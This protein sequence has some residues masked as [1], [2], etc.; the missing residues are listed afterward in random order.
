MS[1]TTLRR[2]ITRGAAAFASVIALG[3]VSAAA[4]APAQAGVVGINPTCSNRSAYQTKTQGLTMIVWFYNKDYHVAQDSTAAR[5]LYKW[6]YRG[7][8]YSFAAG[9]GLNKW[10]K[11]AGSLSY[12][13]SQWK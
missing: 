9:V 8:H 12:T 13:C 2:R 5:Q 11:S 10:V 3:G 6:S 4:A 7:D 1:K